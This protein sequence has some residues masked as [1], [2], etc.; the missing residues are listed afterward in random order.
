MT[1]KTKQPKKSKDNGI[2][3]KTI[4]QLRDSHWQAGVAWR[5]KMLILIAQLRH[6]GISEAIILK[7][8]KKSGLTTSTANTIMDDAE[9][10]ND[11]DVKSIF[12][13]SPEE[14]A[15]EIEKFRKE[16]EK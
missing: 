8:L 9:C 10:Y 12:D 7:E 1:E 11:D 4:R 5:K 14:Y 13:K 15:I 2:N 3:E 6:D 16:R